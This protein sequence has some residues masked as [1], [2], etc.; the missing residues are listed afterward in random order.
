MCLGN[1]SPDL[2]AT[3]AQKTGLHRY[4]YD[5]SVEFRAFSDFEVHDIHT[6]LMKKNNIVKKKN[7]SNNIFSIK[8]KF[9]ECI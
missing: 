7:T 9:I 5:F 4:V 8:C 6:C 3:N 1:I 2:S